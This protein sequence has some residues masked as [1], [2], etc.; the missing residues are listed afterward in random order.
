MGIGDPTVAGKGGLASVEFAEGLLAETLS[1]TDEVG[2]AL[3]VGVAGSA[4]FAAAGLD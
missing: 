2:V 4:E 1:G 3:L